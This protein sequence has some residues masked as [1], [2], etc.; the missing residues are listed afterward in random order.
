MQWY[1]LWIQ[2]VILWQMK[3]RF[4]VSSPTI[5]DKCFRCTSDSVERFEPV[6]NIFQVLL[7]HTHASKMS[8]Q[9]CFLVNFSRRGQYNRCH[10][11]FRRQ[12]LDCVLIILLEDNILV[13]SVLFSPEILQ[14]IVHQTQMAVVR[15]LRHC[16]FR[17]DFS[18][19]NKRPRSYF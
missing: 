1:L 6:G 14:Q 12:Y 2:L 4:I 18:G 9:N 10:K 8:F 3:V 11:R 17:R 13:I 15:P 5:Y 19:Q 16:N 7:L